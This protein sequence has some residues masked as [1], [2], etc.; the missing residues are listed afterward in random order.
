MFS[1]RS[2]LRLYLHEFLFIF[3]Y[4][5]RSIG[6]ILDKRRGKLPTKEAL[7][8]VAKKAFIAA[9]MDN[10]GYLTMDEIELW[11]MNNYEFQKFLNKFGK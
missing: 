1:L 6:K 11:C 4:T 3:E 8:V 9:D 7:R 2:E 10:N 5:C